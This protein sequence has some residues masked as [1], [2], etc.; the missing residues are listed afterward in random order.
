[1]GTTS[2]WSFTVISSR[3]H[4]NPIVA[5]V[6]RFFSRDLPTFSRIPHTR[7]YHSLPASIHVLDDMQ[8]R[9]KDKRDPARP[10]GLTDDPPWISFTH[11]EVDSRY[12]RGI[13]NDVPMDRTIWQYVGISRRNKRSSHE[14]LFLLSSSLP[15][16]FLIL[17]FKSCVHN[18][19]NQFEMSNKK[20]INKLHFGPI[21]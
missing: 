4:T 2:S 9:D 3:H 13:Q 8:Q 21:I 7:T 18:I 19:R 6:D 1:V 17:N 5:I 10:T 20:R 11:R 16:Y 15:K 12:L 14:T